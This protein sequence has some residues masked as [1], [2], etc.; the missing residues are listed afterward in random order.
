MEY[1]LCRICGEK[2]RGVEHVWPKVTPVL[3]ERG[4]ARVGVAPVGVSDI[5]TDKPRFDRTAYQRE[6]MRKWRKAKLTH[7][8][9]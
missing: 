5:E 8:P 4:S 3:P 7:D 6:Y 2:H 9:R 1:P